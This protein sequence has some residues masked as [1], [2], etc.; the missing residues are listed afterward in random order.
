MLYLDINY[1][2]KAHY[3]SREARNDEEPIPDLTSVAPHHHHSHP[4]QVYN[5]FCLSEVLTIF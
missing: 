1:S 3:T 2:M 5:N 4:I